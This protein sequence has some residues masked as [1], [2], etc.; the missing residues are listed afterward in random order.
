M[1]ATILK[2]IIIFSIVYLS[3]LGIENLCLSFSTRSLKQKVK[4]ERESLQ[5]ELNEIDQQAY[6][7]FN[8]LLRESMEVAKEDYYKQRQ[9]FTDSPP[10]KKD[11]EI[12]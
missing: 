1:I 3:C 2:F 9:E 12:I 7:A 11:A 5:K 8:D 10:P 6:K 4:Q